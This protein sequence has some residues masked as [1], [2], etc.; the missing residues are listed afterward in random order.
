[1]ISSRPTPILCASILSARSSFTVNDTGDILKSVGFR[2][3]ISMVS[4]STPLIVITCMLRISIMSHNTL[5]CHFF[6]LLQR[7]LYLY[8][9][10]ELSY[11][12]FTKLIIR[13]NAPSAILTVYFITTLLQVHQIISFF[14]RE[15]S[16]GS[17][18]SCQ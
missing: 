15:S 11:R 16:I 1:M 9:I 8:S 2:C 10:L 13:N 6:R 17:E 5:T 18:N 4:H 14:F 12:K 3:F 7:Q